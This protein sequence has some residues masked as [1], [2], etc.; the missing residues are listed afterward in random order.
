MGASGEPRSIVTQSDSKGKATARPQY[1]QR[2]HGPV[3]DRWQPVLPA[4]G[5]VLLHL[6]YRR[7]KFLKIDR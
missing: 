7:E 3:L 2:P 5:P 4:A 1:R 6:A